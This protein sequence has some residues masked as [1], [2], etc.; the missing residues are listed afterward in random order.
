M[1]TQHTVSELASRESSQAVSCIETCQRQQT[2]K[3]A[4]HILDL[5]F[6]MLRASSSVQ[7]QEK[8]EA[9][10]EDTETGTLQEIA[11]LPC[12]RQRN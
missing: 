1:L 6:V 10:Q 12:Y 4:G 8:Q 11:F 9:E 2:R 3:N 5:L 7:Q